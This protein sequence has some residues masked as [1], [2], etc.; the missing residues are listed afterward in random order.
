VRRQANITSFV[1][2]GVT[3]NSATYISIITPLISVFCGAVLL[4]LATPVWTKVRREDNQPPP[5]SRVPTIRPRQPRIQGTLQVL[6]VTSLGL[7]P[8]VKFDCGGPKN[9]WAEKDPGLD[10]ALSETLAHPVTTNTKTTPYISKSSKSAPDYPS[11]AAYQPRLSTGEPINDD[12]TTQ[13]THHPPPWTGT[14]ANCSICSEDFEHGQDVRLL[15]C[16]HGY[17]PTCVDSWLLE[18]SATCPLW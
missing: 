16:N 3:Q 11:P 8:I 17:H 6:N 9:D 12:R 4:I 14:S 5:I 15:P 18:R 13:T 1:G 2:N 10:C 7:I